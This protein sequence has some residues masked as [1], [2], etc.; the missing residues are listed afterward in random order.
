MIDFYLPMGA[1]PYNLE[2]YLKFVTSFQSLITPFSI[3]ILNKIQVF[4][5]NVSMLKEQR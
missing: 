1:L 3:N 2:G 5:A 4:K